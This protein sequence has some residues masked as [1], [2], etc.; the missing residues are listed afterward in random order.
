MTPR[1]HLAF[2]TGSEHRVR[3]LRALE[4]P[5]RPC[6]LDDEQPASRATIQ[7]TLGGFEDRGWVVKDGRT[8][9]LTAAGD[10]V[11]QAYGEMATLV[12][13]VDET[14]GTLSLL[15]D[16]GLPPAAIA[17]A[18][19]T[20]ASPTTPHAPIERY[21]GVVRDANPDRFRGICPV[22]SVMLNEAHASVVEGGTRTDL[23][24]DEATFEAAR[25]H[26]VGSLDRAERTQTF[27]LHVHT[28]PIE[29]GLSIVDDHVFVGAHDERGRCCATFDGT[30]RHLYEWAVATFDECVA[31]ARTV[32]LA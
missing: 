17:D 8:Y 16:V 26:D 3:L 21:L 11:R 30:S 22:L 7:R 29:Y 14:D 6:E 32:E 4:T 27:S 12:E 1:E 24:I 13:A 2:L 5:R 9:R 10:I 28:D 23:V 25:E 31:N 19:V 20:T 15:S 18:T